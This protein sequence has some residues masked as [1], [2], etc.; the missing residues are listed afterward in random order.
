[1][2]ERDRIQSPDRAGPPLGGVPMAVAPW[3]TEGSMTIG[4]LCGVAL[5]LPLWA[6]VISAGRAAL[7]ALHTALG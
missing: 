6:G 5:S 7:S 3:S 2:I 1:M 4:V